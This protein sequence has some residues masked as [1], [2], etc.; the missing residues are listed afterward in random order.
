MNLIGKVSMNPPEV[1]QVNFFM[2]HL[3]KILASLV[4]GLLFFMQFTGRRKEAVVA[5]AVIK[6]D[7]RSM[8]Q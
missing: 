6:D 1:E 7:S 8:V 3:G 5:R 2:E 4:A